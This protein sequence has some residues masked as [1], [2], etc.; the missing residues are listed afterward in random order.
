MKGGAALSML[1]L[2]V[3]GCSASIEH[4]L[5]EASANEMLT[6]LERAGIPAN[7]TREDAGSFTLNV[8]R[9]EVVSAMELLRSLGLPRGHRPSMGDIFKQGSLLPTP[10]EERARYVEGLGNEIARTLE[11]IDGVMLVHVHLVLPEAEPLSTEGKPRLPAQAAV[12]LKLHAGKPR[13][14]SEAEVRK[15]VAGSVPG[16]EPAAVSVVF[17]QAAAL[18][19]SHVASLVPLGPLRVSAASRV[20]LVIVGVIVLALIVLLAGLILILAR[21]LAARQRHA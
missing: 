8:A 3:L 17:T 18:P 2:L 11:D 20:P 16:L 14:V 19:A 21:K 1:A 9:G 5:D 10:T 13:P 4:G 12:L 6:S 7:K 15:L